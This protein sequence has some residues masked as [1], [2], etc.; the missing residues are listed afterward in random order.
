MALNKT[1]QGKQLERKSGRRAS[2]ER[3]LIVSEGSKTEPNYFGE[4]RAFYRLHTAN[5]E[6]RPSDLGT[7]PLQVVQYARQLFLEGD[8][9]RGIQA[10]AFDQ[11]YAVFDRD[12]HES[13]FNALQL[14]ES[15][16]QKYINDEKQ[17]VLFRAI[18]SVPS[19]ELWL[20]LHFEEIL[21][22]IDRDEVMRRLK[23]Y[24]PQYE[25]G[26]TGIF[27]ITRNQL[28]QACTRAE[29]L[30]TRFSGYTAPEPYT[31]VNALVKLLTGLRT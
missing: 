27:A 5:V 6:V 28:D 12:D 10:R 23:Q 25:K 8:R 29:K 2:Y 24:V 20:L 15:L 18:P 7:A 16:D 21:S 13:Y 22:P 26:A 14:A 11:V 1:R 4:I 3:I 31:A 19:F 17:P 9:H 30:G